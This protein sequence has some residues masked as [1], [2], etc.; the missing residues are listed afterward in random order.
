MP[1]SPVPG[2]AS[3][4]GRFVHLH[5]HTEY[6]MLDG[7]AK[8]VPL[9]AE[10]RRLGMPAVGMTDHGNMFGAYQ[11]YAAAREAQIAPIIGIEAYVAP[12]SRYHKRP[13]FWG[14][15]AQRGTDEFGEGGD[16]SGAG[17]YTHMTMLAENATGLRNLFALS[18]R[19]SMEGYYRKP[20][21]DRELIAE[22]AEGII[23]TTGC[24]SGEVQIRLRLGQR[25]QALAAAADY[26]DIFGPDNFFLE[27]MD[28]GL[29]IERSVRDGLLDIGSRL[30]LRPLAT[31]DSHYVTR[32][33]AAAHEVL[34]CVQSGKTMSDPSRFKLDGD[35]YYL[36]SAAQMREIWDAEVPGATD[37]SLR[38]AE[39][40]GSYDEVFAF[41]DRMP[42]VPLPEG[43]TEA[44]L[45]CK[46][47]E[48][49]GRQRCPDG[50]PQEYR[51][52][53]EAELAL[54]GQMGFSGYFLVVG[55]L[56]RWAKAQQIRVGPG[57]GSATGS[58]VA[59]LLQITDVDPIEHSLIFERF[60]NPER[61]S[62]PDIDLDFDDRRRGEV[63]RYTI[64]RYGAHNVAQVITFGTIK[65]KAAIKDAARV[66]H[67]APG[68]AIADR[69]TKV[70]PPPIMAKDIPL[71]GIV[72]PG[73]PRYAEAAEIRALIQN[74]PEAGKIFQTARALE[75]TIRN[76][77][78][79][80]CA[81]ILSA[82]PLRE[83][84]PLWQRDDGAVI[85]GWDYPSCEAVGLLKMDFLGLSNLTIMGDAIDHVKANRGADIDPAR[86]PLDDPKTFELLAAGHVLGV[87]QLDSP[88]MRQLMRLMA[89]TKFGD[90]VASN[91]LYRPGPMDAKSHLAY[92]ERSNGRAAI[93]PIHPELAAALEP[94]LGETY[95]LVV[96]QEQVMAI[97]QQ[98][99]GYTLGGADVL[100]RAMGKKKKAALDRQLEKFNA[101]MV[102][103]GFSAS[104]IQALWNVL[105]PFSGY[106]FNKS[107]S[108]G[109]GLMTY[110]TAYLK[111]NFAAEYMAA[112][113]TSN[114]DNKDKM[115]TYLGECRRMGVTVLPPDVNESDADFTPRGGDIR[116]GLTA[117]RNVGA[118][119]VASIVGTRAEKG[120]YV[121]FSDFLRKVEAPVCN[122]KVVESLIKAGA[123]DSMGHSRRGLASVHMEAIDACLDTK[124][125]EAVGQFDLFSFGASGAS[126][127]GSA[128]DV[129]VPAP[130]WDKAD[131][132]AYEKDMLGLYVSDHPLLGVE[133]LLAG[134][135]DCPIA[136]VVGDGDRAVVTL[137]G[138][139]STVTTRVT[140]KGEP[141]AQAVLE[142]LGGSIDVM[143]F[144]KLY[145]A[146]GLQVAPDTIVV[147]RGKV[148]RRDESVKFIAMEMSLPDV[149][150][151]P[152]GPVII[153]LPTSRCTPPLIARLKA[154][155]ATHPGTTRVQ[156][157]LRTGSRRTVLQIDDA[158]RVAPTTS[159]MGD[160]KALLGPG[161]VAT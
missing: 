68:F 51:D 102:Q 44:S 142:D 67:G 131:R 148:D 9:L 145:A 8:V 110:W 143:F 15:S 147:V 78:V 130:E 107:H 134:S 132:L 77:G 64:D 90:I 111:A 65:T 84:V 118:N 43:E 53:V 75:G 116:F 20:R 121:D 12:E 161:C 4:D 153:T 113:L 57:R 152:R 49:Y 71:G 39:R 156:L 103:R 56:V 151:A 63:L 89:P 21:M 29:P 54:I 45:L 74:D 141:W 13:I 62:P 140:R 42:R 126:D 48:R 144:P 157:A 91:A 73:H 3:G 124:R 5:V 7:A 22:H 83:V 94:I 61:I 72:D 81:V 160:L 158:L 28:H 93:T 30:G 87:F 137:A 25:E 69:I 35:G 119:V 14:S 149:S 129:T 96:Y 98:L 99:A 138:I 38:I 97:A 11:F 17:A 47:V 135:A 125:A 112:L 26:R 136:D 150:Q 155:L 127:E 122:K 114:A 146:V 31:N 41:T 128:F 159:L 82:Q 10:A 16:V 101:G 55:D 133:H 6:S 40:V 92:A 60:I 95:H 66:L 115:A 70:L 34:L 105:V 85:T 117:V 36:K 109:Y 2:P 104:A 154:V 79:H 27:L 52:R 108:A 88:G 33:Q 18:S 46:E 76:A 23:A 80:A 59:Y 139:L 86:I 120:K 37:T 58:L 32:E 24:P 19:A 1:S 100:R 50:L 106:G 123:F